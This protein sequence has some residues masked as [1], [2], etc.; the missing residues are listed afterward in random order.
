MKLKSAVKADL[1]PPDDTLPRVLSRV[2]RKDPDAIA[3]LRGCAG[4]YRLIHGRMAVPRD[5]TETHNPDGTRKEG[6]LPQEYLLAGDTVSLCDADAAH[7]L[8]NGVIEPID[9]SVSRVGRV[10]EE[11]REAARRAPLKFPAN[12]R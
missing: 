5:R 7:G 10:F 9:T 11:A 3:K 4:A 1:A 6:E 2:P 8:D 12:F